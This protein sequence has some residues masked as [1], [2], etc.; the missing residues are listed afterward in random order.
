MPFP[1]PNI[2]QEDG[3]NF[4]E[5]IVILDLRNH[6]YVKPTELDK[7]DQNNIPNAANTPCMFE[8]VELHPF[9]DCANLQQYLER[10]IV[11]LPLSQGTK[12]VPCDNEELCDHVFYA[13][14]T[15]QM[16]ENI[17]SI[18]NDMH[19]VSTHIQC[20]A[21]N[22]EV[23]KLM[24]S[25]LRE[26]RKSNFGLPSFYHYLLNRIGKYDKKGEYYVHQTY[27]CSDMKS[28]FGPQQEDNVKGCTNAYDVFS[29][30]PSFIFMQQVQLE[31]RGT[32]GW[33]HATWSLFPMPTSK[34]APWL[35]I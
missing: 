23:L 15:Q 20:I 5:C 32:V 11:I 24:S 21:S 9:S 26:N 12:C 35:P 19:G 7:S 18:L 2:L 27:V 28:L 3:N 6:V 8:H 31:E 29:S 17:Q 16:H 33:D 30:S 1:V 4:K 13:L 22:N 10:S 34:D 25:C 14:K